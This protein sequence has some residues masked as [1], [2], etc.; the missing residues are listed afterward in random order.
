[1]P[2]ILIYR[3]MYRHILYSF[4]YTIERMSVGAG[5]HKLEEEKLWIS[6]VTPGM[7]FYLNQ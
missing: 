4:N 6:T 7:K 5:E 2:I 1:M 3:L